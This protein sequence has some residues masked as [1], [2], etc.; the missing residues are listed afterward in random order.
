MDYFEGFLDMKIAS[1]TFGIPAIVVVDTVGE[2]GVL[3]NFAEDEAGTDG[4]YRAGRDE[5]SFA[6][7]DGI[8]ARSS[9]AL[10]SAT[11]RLNWSGVTLGFS[12]TSTLASGP[13]RS[14]YHI[15]VL[16]H[17]PAACSCREAYASS[18]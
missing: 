18:G 16:P 6:R 13:A 2:I 4:V 12:P 15:S 10:P 14:A 3:L 8:L 1:L 9:S 5:N 7:G 11:A 17:P